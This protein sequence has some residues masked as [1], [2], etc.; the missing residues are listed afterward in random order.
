MTIYRHAFSAIGCSNCVLT[1]DATTVAEAG[2]V[3]E[4]VVAELDTVASRFRADLEISRISSRAVGADAHVIVSPLLGSCIEAAL[5]AADIT[6]G[7]VDPTV[8]A[9]VAV[10]GYDADL[11]VVRRRGTL[12]REAI[13]GAGKEP[14][15]V[16]GWR[17]VAYD[18]RTRL[19]SVPRGTVLDLGATAKAHAAD[20]IAARLPAELGGGFL[21]NLGGDIA[22]SG[23]LPVGGWDIG[24]ED[25]RRVV[26]QVVVSAGQAVATSSTRVRTWVVEGERRHHIVDPRTGRTAAG[27]WDQVTCAGISALEANAASTAA[28]VLGPEAPDWL[29][30]HGIPARLDAP[31]GRTVVTPG[32]PQPGR[33]AA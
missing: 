18:V 23:L 7:L 9:A 1:T 22:V 21:V 11:A 14:A 15:T 12:R 17:A 24:V 27:T 5:H 29:T 10:T 30:G 32:W 3:A 19:L 6:D 2:R 20:L 25:E 8:G 16:P 33:R 31:A 28:V 4:K 13:P 26:R